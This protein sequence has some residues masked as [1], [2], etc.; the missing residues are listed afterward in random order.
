[1]GQLLCTLTLL[2]FH[3]NV[4]P[5]PSYDINLKTPL[6]VGGLSNFATQAP[7]VEDNL[8]ISYQGVQCRG[9]VV[10][11]FPNK[12]VKGSPFI[13]ILEH[14]SGTVCMPKEVKTTASSIAAVVL[15]WNPLAS[16]LAS[17][18][19]TLSVASAD[20]VS[21]EGVAD[22]AP[23]NLGLQQL[24]DDGVLTQ[25]AFDRLN[26]E[27]PSDLLAAAQKLSTDQPDLVAQILAT[28][29]I[30]LDQVNQLLAL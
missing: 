24:L 1:M 29:P 19:T 16:P 2:P 28:T 9:T 12:N 21:I 5:R 17:D 27:D 3:N 8:C 14:N 6:P 30:T 4:W 10:S 22:D 26:K 25:E 13:A 15:P 7:A 23:A 11:V 20:A 18:V